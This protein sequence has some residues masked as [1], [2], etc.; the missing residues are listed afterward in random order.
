MAKNTV[1]KRRTTKRKRDLRRSHLR[2]KLARM[3]NRT[4]PVKVF[5]TKNESGKKLTS[6]I[7]GKESD[8]S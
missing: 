5:T 6:Q 4:S 7:R 1:P 8:K 2:L 3:V